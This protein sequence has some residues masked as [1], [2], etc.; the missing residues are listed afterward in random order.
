MIS[1]YDIKKAV[2]DTL[3]R[4]F[5]YPVYEFGLVEG[6]KFPC[7]F[8]RVWGKGEIVTRNIY[9]QDYTVEIV[10]MYGKNEKGTEAAVLKDMKKMRQVFLTHLK[11]EQRLLPVSDFDTDYT[12]ERGN[13]PRFLF[14]IDF[15]E[16]LYKT[17]A[18]EMMKTAEI[19][20]VKE[21]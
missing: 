10:M 12:G 8:A 19:N 7:L 3:R 4:N 20:F 21:E 2:V 6:M 15:F 9:H 13:I 1:E 16:S 5:E 18:E 14:N 11:T 17:E